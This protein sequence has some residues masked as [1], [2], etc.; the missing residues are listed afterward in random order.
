MS[1][2]LLHRLSTAVLVTAALA[3]P[4]QAQPLSPEEPDY[5]VPSPSQ[6]RAR[7][8]AIRSLAAPAFGQ[9][10]RVAY[11]AFNNKTYELTRFQ[12]RHVELLLPDTWT[13]PGAL[14]E[15]QIRGFVD[16]TDLIYQHLLDLVGTPPAGE[17]LLPV[18]I[19][20]ET[21]GLGCGF[22]GMKGVEME[23]DPGLRPLFWQEIA[24]DIPSGVFIHE[25][26]HNFDVF[27]DYLAYTPDHAHAWTNFISYYYSAYTR[28]GAL[29]IAPDEVVSQWLIVTA[30]YFKDPTADWESCV[31]EDLCRDRGISPELSWGGLGFRLA[32]FDGPQTV[33]GF[34]TFLRQYRQS[35]QPPATAEGRNDLYVEALA[36]GARRNLSCVAD[37]WRWHV[38]DSLRQR[39]RERYRAPN[40]DCQDRDRDGFSLLQG[41]CNDHQ[42]T[43]HPGAAER[44]RRVDDDCDGRVD[45]AVLREPAGGDFATPT[46][47]TLPAEISGSAGSSLDSDEFLLRMKSPGRVLIDFCSAQEAP[48]QV[49]LISE[50]GEWGGSVILIGGGCD[51]KVYSLSAGTLSFEV[52][53]GQGPG[54]DRYSVGIQAA[55]PSPVPRSWARTAPPRRS[56]NRFILT[57][58]AR[59]PLPGPPTEIRFWVSGQGIVGTVPYSRAA[60]FAWTPPAGVDPAGLSYRA[61]VLVRGVPAAGITRPQPFMIP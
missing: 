59:S 38:S 9:G 14:S 53:L 33:R 13:G 4:L 8:G 51:Q 48:A 6:L 50:A 16:R 37:T 15:E 54:G 19:V 30:P 21:C 22:L 43:V 45:E 52:H 5:L 27:H 40:P 49:V 32:L 28:E 60:S 41:D 10:E 55:A 12:G 18:A 47:L 3:G 20:P 57:A 34:M 7:A 23:D 11:R 17:G 35:N 24:A 1:H 26:I 58:T 61:Q 29:E 2:S 25:M 46:Q 56:G 36:A 44:I 39:M 42:S 31:R